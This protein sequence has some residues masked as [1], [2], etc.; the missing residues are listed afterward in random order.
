[1]LTSTRLV[2]LL[3][4]SFGNVISS[5]D[6]EPIATLDVDAYL[7][8][9]YQTY[10][11]LGFVLLELGG[12]CT[13]ADYELTDDG[14]I[15]LVNQSRPPLIPQ[16]FAR[17]TGFAVQAPPGGLEGAFTVSQQY[18]KEGD[19]DDVVY[20]APGNY[21]ILGIGPIVNNQYQWAVVSNPEKTLCFVIARDGEN[22][23]GSDYEEDALAVLE[24]FG[25]NTL[26]NKP[27][28]TSHVGCKGYPDK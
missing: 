20:E 14:K 13:T 24:N 2:L 3:L 4:L 8:R 6:Y 26:K 5:Q 28:P 1:M 23:K 19:S 17:T 25:F 18:L 16:I 7:G 11:N 10:A 21:W 27:L 12:K 9:W 15:A 22:F